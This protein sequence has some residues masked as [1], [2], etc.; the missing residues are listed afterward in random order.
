VVEITTPA[1]STPSSPGLL[2]VSR[3]GLA[4]CLVH[5][6]IKVAEDVKSWL[7]SPRR[8]GANRCLTVVWGQNDSDK[9]GRSRLRVSVVQVESPN[10]QL[11][12]AATIGGA[13]YVVLSDIEVRC[14]PLVE[15]FGKIDYSS[16]RR[17]GSPAT[18][19]F[20]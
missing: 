9:L 3:D 13:K 5:D 11:S 18:S 2:K 6:G 8:M 15:K 4:G 20:S 19:R 10:G 1:W 17:L 12:G 16:D 7:S 14:A